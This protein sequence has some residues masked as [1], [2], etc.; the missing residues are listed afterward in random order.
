MPS[1]EH[2]QIQEWFLSE[3]KTKIMKEVNINSLLNHRVD[4][5]IPESRIAIEIQCSPLSMKE[6]TER[7]LTYV[8]DNYIPVWVF[9]KIFY[10]NARKRGQNRIK[11]IEESE[12]RTWGRIFYHNKYNLFEAN[13]TKKYYR[14]K[15][16]W[17]NLKKISIQDFFKTILKG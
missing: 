7:N 13:F 5:L 6:Y 1:L 11:D 3:I 14:K 10:N 4:V 9:G 8:L 15:L 12:L 2:N 17:Y 16:G